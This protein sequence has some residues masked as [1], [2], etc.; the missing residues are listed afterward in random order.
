MYIDT[1]SYEV[2]G[3]R[4]K[5]ALVRRNEGGERLPGLVMAPNWMGVTNDAVSRAVA[6]AEHGYVVFVADVYGVDHRPASTEAAAFLA[7]EIRAKP[8]EARRRM[9]KALAMLEQ[10]G[11]RRSLLV[12]RL[13]AA[14]GFCLGGG[15][16][17]ELARAGAP[18][19]A[20]ISIHGD[21]TTLLPATAGAIRASV[22]ALHGALDPIV[23]K[24]HRDAFEREMSSCDATWQ[25]L[26]YGKVLHAY[27]DV[28]ANA[29][30]VAV[31]DARAAAHTYDLVHRFIADAFQ[32]A[33]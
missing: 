29:P 24:A 21:L 9:L 8:V 7:N 25:L 17:L 31:Y 10:E 3:L 19:Q 26:V 16:V 32:Q 15:N 12:P 4:C 6:F 33:A 2:S 14:V 30:P 20:A 13:R 1:I 5:G 18:I 22:L 11:T 27:T 23:P 28:D